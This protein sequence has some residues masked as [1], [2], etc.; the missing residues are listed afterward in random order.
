MVVVQWTVVCLGVVVVV[1]VVVVGEEREKRE[2]RVIVVGKRT[3]FF[4]HS[5][6]KTFQKQIIH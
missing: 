5:M 4:E 2:K 3:S 1:V 6:N